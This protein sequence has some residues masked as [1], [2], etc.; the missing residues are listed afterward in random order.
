[1]VGTSSDKVSW[2]P[3][4]AGPVEKK[5]R[6]SRALRK[7]VKFFPEAS[8]S[9]HDGAAGSSGTKPN[10]E[11]TGHGVQAGGRG[12]DST[13]STLSGALIS[14]ST[15]QLEIHENLETFRGMM[16]R[17]NLNFCRLAFFLFVVFVF[18]ALAAI[19][20]YIFCQRLILVC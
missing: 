5:K 13:V 20:N 16:T 11:D 8:R 7:K 15:I 14:I 12:S 10:D 4:V 6:E 2:Q 3:A 1:M 19:V 17:R 9:I 18:A